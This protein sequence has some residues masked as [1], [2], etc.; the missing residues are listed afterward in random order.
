MFP[1]FHFNENEILTL[2]LVLLRTSAFIVSWPVFAVF[3]VPNIAKILFALILAIL[4][5]PAIDRSALAE[6]RLNDQLYFLSLREV[7]IGLCMGFVCRMFFFALSIGG[8][9]ISTSIGLASAQVYNPAIGSQSTTV[10]QFYL[11]LATLL[12]LALNGHHVF[13]EGLAKSFELAPLAMTGA[14]STAF[15][16]TTV[17]VHDVTVAGLQISAPV[18]VAI[19]LMNI[20][21][22]ILGRAVPQINVLITSLPVNV[23][24]GLGVMIVSIPV[25]LPETERL[26]KSMSE[27]LF[28]M[29]KAF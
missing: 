4:M 20:F 26:M 3:S 14:N 16:E 22:G 24:V 2:A 23:L 29:M 10:E 5:F 18:M 6:V 1:S 19:F 12:F 25:L 17:F 27:Y 28:Q 9:L 11:A 21:M 13:I 7:F 15:R 8:N